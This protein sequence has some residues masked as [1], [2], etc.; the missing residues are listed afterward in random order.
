MAAKTSNGTGRRN[1]YSISYGK[2]STRVKELPEGLTKITEEDLKSATTKVDNID[3]RNKFMEKAG[4]YPFVVFYDT[5][6]G[7]IQS[8]VK[9]EFDQGV[10]LQMEVLDSDDEMSTI[11][12]RFYSKYTENILNR[13]ANLDSTS[14]DIIFTPYAIPSEFET[15]D[16]KTIKLY[17][18]GV[19][20]KVS[21][22]KVE[23]KY[24]GDDKKLPKTVQIKN[25]QGKNETSRV[26]RIDFLFDEVSKKFSNVEKSAPK[27]SATPAAGTNDVPDDDLPF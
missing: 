20:L 6:Q 18:Q 17:N 3:L 27:A 19:S 5:I 26:D 7:T 25:A 2:L 15:P 4:D 10:S 12:V 1:F 13:L 22:E 24:K 23:V 11:Q 16:G 8:V 14:S 21:G 9:N